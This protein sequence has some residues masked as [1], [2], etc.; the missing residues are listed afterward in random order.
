MRWPKEIS[1]GSV[2]VETVCLCDLMA[3]CA[4]IVG[5]SLPDNAGEDSVSNLPIWQGRPLDRS[6]REATIHHSIDG[7]FSIQQTLANGRMCMT[8]MPKSLK[9]LRLC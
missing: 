9:N 2:S 7:S 5:T 8:S 3:T 6:L 4:E 1:A